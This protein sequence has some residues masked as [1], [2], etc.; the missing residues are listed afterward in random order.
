MTF[1]KQS[2]RVIEVTEGGA[3]YYLY[4]S[5]IANASFTGRVATVTESGSQSNVSLQR[6]VARSGG[7]GQ[8]VVDAT[9]KAN[10]KTTTVTTD[11]EG[12]F[13]IDDA[14][15]GDEY[16]I[17]PE[18]ESP[19]TV[20]P[21]ADGDDVGT[22][23]VVTEGV[24]FKTSIVPQSGYSCDMNELYAGTTYRFNL[25][26]ENTGDADCSIAT[27]ALDWDDGLSVTKPADTLLQT[28]EP[29]MKKTIAITVACASS[30]IPGDKTFKKIRIT[31]TDNK[32]GG[33]WDDSVS[34]KFHKTWVD[35][36]IRAQSGVSGILIAPT[37]KTYSFTDTTSRTI[38]A[39]WLLDD[40]L[41]VFSG[42]AA[43][44]ETRYSFAVDTTPGTDWTTFTDFMNYEPNNTESGAAAVGN[45]T[46][47]SYLHKN[48]I[49]YYKVSLGVIFPIRSAPS[50]VTAT[51]QSSSSIVLSWNTVDGATSYNVYRAA[52]SGG[53]YSSI[54][55]TTSAPYTDIGLLANTTYYYKVSAVNSLGEGSQSNYVTAKT[56]SA[57]PTGL[58][59][60][61]QSS[62][63]V[64]IWWTSAAG[65]SSYKVYRATSAAGP[66]SNIGTSTGTST[67]SPYTNTGLS[68]NTNYYYKVSAVNSA[69]EGE[70]SEYASAATLPECDLPA[71]TVI[72]DEG[73]ERGTRD[74][75][76][77][78][79][80]YAFVTRANTA[81]TVSLS[82][83]GNY[84]ITATRETVSGE[85][86][87]NCS[88]SLSDPAYSGTQTIQAIAQDS[89]VILKIYALNSRPKF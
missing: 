19:V 85:S 50:G 38:T 7:W 77:V 86:L 58:T 47:M 14:I 70:Q 69:G 76:T 72:L 53:S 41:L 26:V 66:Y 60:A 21:Q 33:T 67:Y 82:I 78:T 5:R 68:A 63:S 27:W 59:A 40:Y 79:K 75:S 4:A 34:L 54:G 45:E 17:T 9:N 89:V 30:A 51:A 62:S 52:S 13:E 12:N 8:K 23:T 25:S 2:D 46:I 55:T 24:N 64:K 18:G 84:T 31:I 37:G 71:N 15:P 83:T 11:N 32:N 57:A 36:N 16:E 87:F 10:G 28:I 42:A 20:T 73:V 49:D 48:D 56:F 80:Y 88:H 65:A 6:S 1:S 29:G 35:F 3:K 74:D 22:I 39:P 44:T 81:Y 43:E 61:V